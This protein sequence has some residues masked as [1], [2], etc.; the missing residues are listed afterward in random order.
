M[1]M[2]SAFML[3]A[4][5]GIGYLLCILAKKEKGSIRVL[6]FSLGISIIVLSL[7]YGLIGTY[8]K[9]CFVTGGKGKIYG[10]MMKNC[11]MVKTRR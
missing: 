9:Q 6:G 8:A 11:P 5:L 10:K 3:F 7:V 4:S 2:C 1:M